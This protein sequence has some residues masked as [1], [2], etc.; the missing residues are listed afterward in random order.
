MSQ[1]AVRDLRL[2]SD[3]TRSDLLDTVRMAWSRWA[4]NCLPGAATWAPT[5]D[6]QHVAETPLPLS[7]GNWQAHG[8]HA[9][10][11]WS[12]WSERGRQHLAARLVQRA[13]SAPCLPDSDWALTAADRAWAA[14]NEQ[15][16]G[17]PLHSPDGLDASPDTR[18]WSGLVFVSEPVLE[19]RWALRLPALS[20]LSAAA[21]PGAAIGR[22]VI[23]CVSHRS[24]RLQV[25]LGEVDITLADLLALQIGD[26]VRFPAGHGQGV[27]FRLGGTSRI[28]GHG[29]LGLIDGH[30]ALRFS[31]PSYIRS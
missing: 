15:L 27:P 29:Q 17:P 23:D 26:V 25:E 30:L 22:S 6:V 13:P 2:V 7:S 21:Q 1:P 11:G 3:R 19:T 14:L 10:A 12:Q 5:F 9:V 31:S 20:S 16:L 28:A 8:E 24:L 4:A 18:P